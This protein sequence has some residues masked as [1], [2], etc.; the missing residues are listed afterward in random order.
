MPPVTLGE[1]IIVLGLLVWLVHDLLVLTGGPNGSKGFDN[2]IVNFFSSCLSV[3]VKFLTSAES[4]LQP[5]VLAFRNAMASGGKPIGDVISNDIKGLAINSFNAMEKVLTTGHPSLPEEAVALGGA[6]LAEAFSFGFESFAVTAAFEAAFPE[7]LNVLNGAGPMLAQLAGFAEITAAIRDPLY[8]NAFG[9]SADYYYKSLFKPEFPDEA[10]AVTWHSRRLLGDP[11]L[12]TIFKYSGLK[13]E[14]EEPYIKSAYRSVQPRA[15]ATAI[16]DTPFPVAEMTELLQFGGYRDQDVALLLTA[17]EGASTRNVRNQYLSSITTAAERGTLSA[18]EVESALT[19]LNFSD[20]A[21][22]WV[23]LTIATRKLEQ[24]AEIYRK[25]VSALYKFSLITDAQYVP[26]LEAIGI[27]QADANA[28]YALDSAN[29]LG[30][31]AAAAAREAARLAAEVTRAASKAALANYAEHNIDELALAA[32]LAVAGV[33]A[34]VIPWAVDVAA[35]RRQASM[36]NVF[37]KRV[38]TDAAVLLREQVAALKEQVIK[39]LLDTTSARTQLQNLGLPPT[40]VEDLLA[41]WA[42]QALKTVLPV[43]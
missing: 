12:R 29:K 35:L 33:P 15:I 19:D 38:T 34:Q 26:A 8:A 4:Q 24:L 27:A 16:Q 40:D 32:A 43:Q 21:K 36:R 14:Y 39:K 2:Y 18:A 42:A 41:R 9:K 3:A 20:Q 30:H 11:E 28:H 22:H 6:G 23:Q 25:E 37:G 17:F 1:I 5:I 13:A 31:E 7:K 10:D